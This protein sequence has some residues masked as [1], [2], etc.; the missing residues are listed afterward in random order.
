MTGRHQMLPRESF[1]LFDYGGG[2][3]LSPAR[4]PATS[5][6]PEKR[7]K[8][9][10]V[11]LPS[12]QGIDGLAFAPGAHHESPNEE[13]GTEE[14]KRQTQ[15]S[16]Q[17]G[18]LRCPGQHRAECSKE[19]HGKREGDGQNIVQGEANCRIGRT[20]PHKGFTAPQ[21]RCELGAAIER[22][23]CHLASLMSTRGPMV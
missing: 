14:E 23:R 1:E 18:C 7:N 2:G 8:Y 17:S 4:S 21:Q 10:L 15:P 19:S 12:G 5:L 20:S 6:T 3:N 13:V 11:L 16:R 22:M 9:F